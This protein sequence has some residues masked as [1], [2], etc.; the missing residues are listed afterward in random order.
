MT[1]D[2][3]FETSA[4]GWSLVAC[5]LAQSTTFARTATHSGKL[6]ATSTTAT[7]SARCTTS[8]PVVA[9]ALCT[10]NVWASSVGA[11]TN[12]T[13]DIDWYDVSNTLI[14]S[15]S[16][17][18]DL[19]SGSAWTLVQLQATAPAGTTQARFGP[20]LH[21]VTS[22]QIVYLD[23]VTFAAAAIAVSANSAYPPQVTVEATNLVAG[24]TVSVYR[25]LAGDRTVLRGADELLQADP[26]LVVFD[27]EEPFGT[28]ITYVLVVDGADVAV[29]AP[30][31]VMLPGGKVVVSDA[32]TGLAVETIITAWPDRT[33]DRPGTQYR[34]GGRTVIVSSPRGSGTEDVEFLTETETARLAM[35]ALLDA[36][37][38][39]ILLV[40]QPG[41]YPGVD[42]Y[43]A[44]TNDVES[45]VAQDGKLER[46]LW[47][48]SLVGSDPWAP[49]LVAAASNT[50]QQV[51][52]EY[53]G[54]D[55]LDLHD[56]FATYL[57]MDIFDWSGL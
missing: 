16:V 39:N 46:R 13:A 3:T 44:V 41:G 50:Y 7:V 51:T 45:R 53:V 57:D 4:A 43:Y 56:D 19:P 23:D 27:A 12:I 37:T 49:A 30:I 54:L 15:S 34:V 2:G 14:S 18:V 5:T 9:G 33:H 10:L 38:S 21:T 55:Y 40:R 35:D 28:P 29:S 8:Y 36:A 25:S 52:D 17:D 26:S 1:I 48:M 22:G 6:T 11:T 24:N 47:T 32:I 42:G 20:T 31:T